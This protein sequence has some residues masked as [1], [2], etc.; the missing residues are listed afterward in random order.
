MAIKFMHMRN[1]IVNEQSE[2][3]G[4]DPLGGMTIAYLEEKDQV[5]GFAIARCHNRDNYVKAVGRAKAAGRLNSKHYFVKVDMPRADFYKKINALWVDD[6][7][8]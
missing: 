7:P 4:I 8:V 2:I 6:I 1:A 5:K 3:Q